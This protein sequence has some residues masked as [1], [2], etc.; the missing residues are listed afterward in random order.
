M[1]P[2][3][4]KTT[5]ALWLA[6]NLTNVPLAM[7]CQINNQKSQI[8][9]NTNLDRLGKAGRY[10]QLR[11]FTFLHCA[12]ISIFRI[13]LDPAWPCQLVTIPELWFLRS[14]LDCRDLGSNGP[15]LAPCQH[16]FNARTISHRCEGGSQDKQ[17]C[18]CTMAGVE[19]DRC[20]IAHKMSN[21]QSEKQS[22]PNTNLDRLGKTG[23]Y[24]KLRSFTV[25]HCTRYI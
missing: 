15:I 12:I 5:T 14:R 20:A 1:A 7:K 8:F 10:L 4:S 21:Q 23:S 17:I 24:E 2:K 19:L 11:S 18:K 22:F 13:I 6:S 16:N 25:L 9:P 3:T